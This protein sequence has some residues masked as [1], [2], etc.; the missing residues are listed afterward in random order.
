M[1]AFQIADMTCKHCEAT[2]TKTV[3]EIDAQAQVIIDLSAHTAKIESTLG[4][5]VIEKAIV[6]A[7]F[8]PVRQA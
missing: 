7:G 4:I 6:D 8:T 3:K 5:E 2:I 1:H